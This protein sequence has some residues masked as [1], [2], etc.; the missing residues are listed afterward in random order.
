LTAKNIDL[1]PFEQIQIQPGETIMSALERY[2]KPRK[3]VI[4]SVATGGILALGEHPAHS[5]GT[6]TEG[7]D[8][9]RANAVVRDDRIYRRL[10]TLGQAGG[11]DKAWGAGQNQQRADLT[12][13]STRNRH[14]VTVMDIADKMHGVHQR[15]G[16]E[17]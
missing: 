10:T 2:A 12:G 5:T 6:L 7:V 11:S 9:L 8:I 13:T 4:G 17:Y 15:V 1:E 16:M 3:I 14:S